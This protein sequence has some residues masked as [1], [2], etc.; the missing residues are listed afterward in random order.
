MLVFVNGSISSALG[1]YAASSPL[2][3]AFGGAFW[4]WIAITMFVYAA[5]PASGGHLNPLITLSTFTA[6]L[7]TLPRTVLYVVAQAIGAVIG[8]FL[9]KL[10]LGGPNYF[11]TVCP[12]SSPS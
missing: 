8:A 2:A 12:P 9:L 3:V 10:G 5:A 6:G 1:Q 7:S 11:P 4:N